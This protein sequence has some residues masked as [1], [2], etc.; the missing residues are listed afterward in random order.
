MRLIKCP[1]CELNYITEDEGYCKVCKREMR[2]ERQR[3][4]I[5]MCTVCN[6]A[7]ALP[8]KDVCLFCLKEMNEESS[9]E[10]EENGVRVDEAALSIDPVSG[11][12]EII[13]EMDEDIPEREY[14]E[15]ENDLSLEEMGED[16]D[17]DDD[18]E[19]DED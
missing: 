11:M 9:R 2:G 17:E 16:E 19:E 12:D 8:G 4:E 10:E 5:E 18:D 1:R 14:N 15:I 7:P 6:E 3:D 13:P